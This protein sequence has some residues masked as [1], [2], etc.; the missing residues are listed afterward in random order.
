[1]KQN[2]P[3][4]R[5]P[6]MKDASKLDEAI[7][8]A[9]RGIISHDADLTLMHLLNTLYSV[10]L[11]AVTVEVREAVAGDLDAEAFDDASWG[12]CTERVRVAIVAT[13]D[14]IG[15]EVTK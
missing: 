1:M 5:T 15:T 2:T 12:V 11:T 8:K 10:D 13:A 6:K 7:A 3:Q 9:R 4:Q 14:R